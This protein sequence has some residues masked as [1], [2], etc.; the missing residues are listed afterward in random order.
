MTRWTSGELRYLEDHAGD[1]A[2]SIAKALGRTEDSVRWQAS[3][4]GLSLRR[5]WMCPKCG[6]MTP[7]PL[8]PKTGWCAVCTKEARRG[9]LERELAGLREEIEREREEDRRRQALYARRNRLKNP[10]RDTTYWL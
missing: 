8:N 3:Q 9:E 4:Y 1:G 10:H 5:R 7:K 6:H 2:A